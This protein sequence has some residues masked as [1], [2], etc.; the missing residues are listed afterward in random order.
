[1][2]DAAGAGSNRLGTPHWDP[3]TVPQADVPRKGKAARMHS[4]RGRVQTNRKERKGNAAFSTGVLHKV[5]DL[6]GGVCSLSLRCRIV[7]DSACGWSLTDDCCF[8]RKT[9]ENILST[10]RADDT[11]AQETLRKCATASKKLSNRSEF[12]DMLPLAYGE[13]WS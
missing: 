7:H 13:N 2:L 1:M 9:S 4:A 3:S 11:K 12:T 8:A 10:L 5:I 6:F